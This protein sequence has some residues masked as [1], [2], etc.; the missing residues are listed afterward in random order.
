MPFYVFISLVTIEIVAY[1][2]TLISPLRNLKLSAFSDLRCL[3]LVVNLNEQIQVRSYQP[4][5]ELAKEAV[6]T[7]K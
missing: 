6:L 5:Q 3:V 4:V 1:N 2:L 7:L